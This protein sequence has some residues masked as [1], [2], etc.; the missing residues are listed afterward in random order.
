[1]LR[2]LLAS[3]RE[4]RNPLTVGY[5]ALLA[6]WLA[7][8][9]A[10]SRAARSDVLGERLL[11]AVDSMGEAAKLALATFAAAVV[12]SLLWNAFVSRLVR[13]ISLRAGHPDWGALIREARLAVQ[14]YEE[15][16]VTT[17][18]AGNGTT[19]WQSDAKHRVPSAHRGAYLHARVD[20]RERRAA[21]MSFR[22]TL[23]VSLFPVAVCLGAVGGGWWWSSV[24]VLPVLWFDVAVM[25]HTTLGTVNRYKLEDVRLRLVDKQ[26][27]LEAWQSRSPAGTEPAA[28]P[29]RTSSDQHSAR[30]RTLEEEC[31]ALKAEA[32]RL[33]RDQ[34]RPSSKF[35]SLLLGEGAD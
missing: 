5:S 19:P 18:K 33:I 30:L 20:E 31:A 26:Q 22:V 1:M 9:E 4:L 12:G 2:D 3:A 13:S 7:V 16:D 17:Y 27:T 24:A 25:K 34:C 32:G 6:A 23:A 15:Y 28:K 11:T 10:V 8:G 21:E 35:F 29:S 14:R